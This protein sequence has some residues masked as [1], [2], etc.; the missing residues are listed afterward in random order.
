MMGT[1]CPYTVTDVT[2]TD[3]TDMPLSH[4]HEFLVVLDR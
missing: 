1:C 3:D 2:E 4:A